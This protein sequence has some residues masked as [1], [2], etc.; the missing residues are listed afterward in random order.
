VSGMLATALKYADNEWPVFPLRSNSKLPAT[1][2]GCKDATTDEAQIHEWF[3][4]E[5]PCN[6]GIATGNRSGL[7][8]I[9]IDV[10]KGVDGFAT[11]ARL[12]AELGS[13][14]D[15]R[16]VVTPSGGAHLYFF[17]D[18][19]LRCSTGTL[20][21]GI[22]VRCD[23]GYVV[24]PPSWITTTAYRWEDDGPILPLPIAW[25]TRIQESR[26]SAGDF[27]QLDAQ[28]VPIGQQEDVLN[29]RACSLRRGGV[30][31]AAAVAGLWADVQTWGQ[32]PS[33]PWTL[34]DVE[35]KVD[36]AW[37]DIEPKPQPVPAAPVETVTPAAGPRVYT[38]AEARL[39]VQ[40]SLEHLPVLGIDGYVVRGW[41]H[42]LA[43]WWRLGKSEFAAAVILPWL[44]SGLRVLWIT[45]EP[46]SLW[47]HRADSFDE[48]YE[49]IPWERLTLV[50]AMSAPAPELLDRVVSIE[51][52]VVIAD[53]VREVC[54]INS[55]RD[56]DEVRAK[57]GPWVRRLR[58]GQ[59]TLLFLTQHRKS[60][61][62][63]GERVEGSVALPSMMDVVLEL[64][65]VAGQENRRRL[66][67]R[68]RGAQT[69]PL[70]YE[71]DDLGRMV[72]IPDARSRSRQEAEAAALFVVN[73][74]TAPLTSIQVRRQMIPASRDTVRR[75]LTTLAEKGLILRDPPITEDA[76]RRTVT[77]S[78]APADHLDL[79]Q[80]F[81]PHRVEFTAPE[82]VAPDGDVS[83]ALTHA[84]QRVAP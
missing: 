1:E 7:L 6:V 18:Q 5:R 71:M 75:A 79:A 53:T 73:E 22:D 19:E 78:P 61:G 40:E 47:V 34:A 58:D 36:H 63:H 27:H 32:D 68:R 48:V 56:D 60:A 82:G 35:S 24:A 80:N 39:R 62:E 83:G 29:R 64:E 30:S 42:L 15:T 66:N 81:T 57:V 74:S 52:D 84:V 25:V 46:D 38:I 49:P 54:G 31:R 33:R 8:V 26:S 14:S 51:A 59:R 16:T 20:G 23:G 21:P 44:R 17:V 69:L 41:S 77:W 4:D 3:G 2:H 65:Y 45:E 13:I 43:G 72:V 28:P 9:D 70:V 76:G 12:E 10:K 50:D 11:L 37:R 55:M 67:V